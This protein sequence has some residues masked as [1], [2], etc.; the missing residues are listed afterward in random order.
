MTLCC[1][2]CHSEDVQKL[3]IIYDGGV[4][5]SS[6]S[7]T[8]IGGGY[9][10]RAAIGAASTSSSGTHVSN[11]AKK[12]A[13]P[14]KDPVGSIVFVAM[15]CALLMIWS[16]WWAIGVALLVFAAFKAWQSNRK[17]WPKLLEHW[18]SSFMCHRCGEIFTWTRS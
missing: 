3:S 13:P 17:E 11:L 5:H 16:L 1:P 15:I 14:E 9:A 7:S 4:S 6:S 8:S 10:G 2:A 18:E 12:A